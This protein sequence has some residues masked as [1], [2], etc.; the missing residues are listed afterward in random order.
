VILGKS[1]EDLG[2][3]WIFAFQ[4][5]QYKKKKRRRRRRKTQKIVSGKNC[6]HDKP[7]RKSTSKSCLVSKVKD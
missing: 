5:K 2:S 7:R 4:M 3:Y 6:F 1:K